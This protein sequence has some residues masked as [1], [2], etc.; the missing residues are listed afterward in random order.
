MLIIKNEKLF[1]SDPSRRL[2]DIKIEYNGSLI[3]LAL[4]TWQYA[5]MTIPVD[6]TKYKK[7]VH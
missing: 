7:T 5:G 4:P 6:L 3:E 2:D 1:V